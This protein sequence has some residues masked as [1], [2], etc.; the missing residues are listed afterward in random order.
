GESV[1]DSRPCLRDAVADPGMAFDDEI[2]GEENAD[3]FDPEDGVAQRVPA[4][5]R[6][7]GC[8]SEDALLLECLVGVAQLERGQLAPRDLRKGRLRQLLER[9][10]LESGQPRRG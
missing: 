4:A 3:V 7:R 1:E 10:R 9:R 6:E 2:G 5:V 8:A